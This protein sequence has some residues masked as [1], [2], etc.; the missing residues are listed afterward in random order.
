MFWV[1]SKKQWLNEID[2]S[3]TKVKKTTQVAAPKP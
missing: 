2:K 3:N 1:E